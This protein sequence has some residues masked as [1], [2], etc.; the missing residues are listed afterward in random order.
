MT[1]ERLFDALWAQASESRNDNGRVQRVFWPSERYAFDFDND[2]KGWRQFDTDQD[3]P[4]FGFWTRAATFQTLTYCE[5]DVTLVTCDDVK[6]YNAEID[7][8]CRFYRAAA[9]FI[10]YDGE[11]GHMTRTEYHEDRAEHFHPSWAAPASGRA[12]A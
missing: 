4:H 7:D 11:P 5:G 8:A 2:F 3:A 1:P 12:R 6:G 9:A 10:T